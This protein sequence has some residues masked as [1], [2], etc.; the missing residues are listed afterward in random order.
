[1]IKK[2]KGKL[3][4]IDPL[5]AIIENNNLFYSLHT[6]LDVFENY[7]NYLGK[8]ITL[9]TRLIINKDFQ[10]NF[11][12]F[13]NEKEA[14]TFDFLITLPGIGSRTAINLISSIGSNMFYEAIKN[15][16]TDILTKAPGIGKSKADKIIFEANQK[17]KTGKEKTVKGIDQPDDAILKNEQENMIH[18]VL[19]SLGFSEKEILK[20]DQRIQ[21]QE[22]GTLPEISRQN[23]NLWVK[24]Y[25]KYL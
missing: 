16:K 5:S 3:S 8:E 15:K 20:A 18:T 10:I 22:K 12:G 6:T 24:I 9:Y 13:H 23:I 2:I 4:E 1:M 19:E 7:K 21:S 17:L 25:L 11:Y 14:D